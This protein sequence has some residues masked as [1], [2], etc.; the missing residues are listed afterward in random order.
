MEHAAF[1]T[2]IV[3]NQSGNASL[4][5]RVESDT[6]THMLFVDSGNNRVAVGHNAPSEVLH[7]VDSNPVVT[8]SSSS[9]DQLA[10]LELYEQKNGTADLGGFFE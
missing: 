3:F 2:T 1:D 10:R 6:K 9:V 7:V 4:D 5:F 8:I